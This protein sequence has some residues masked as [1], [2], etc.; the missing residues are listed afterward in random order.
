M[1]YVCKEEV[2]WKMGKKTAYNQIPKEAVYILGHIIKKEGLQNL[3]HTH[4]E[5]NVD[6]EK[7]RIIYVKSLG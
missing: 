7:R 4:I 1:V 6:R 2:L 3:T 5:G